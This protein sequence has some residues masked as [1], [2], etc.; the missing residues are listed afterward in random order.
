MNVPVSVMMLQDRTGYEVLQ[1]KHVDQTMAG[2]AFEEG[3]C[4][5]DEGGDDFRHVNPTPGIVALYQYQDF[6]FAVSSMTKLMNGTL[7]VIAAKAYFL[8]RFDWRVDELLK[9]DALLPARAATKIAKVFKNDGHGFSLMKLARLFFLDGWEIG[10]KRIMRFLTMAKHP[11][12]IFGPKRLF[13]RLQE[14]WARSRRRFWVMSSGQ[15]NA[16]SSTGRVRWVGVS[17][18][19]FKASEVA[20][21]RALAVSKPGDTVMAVHYPKD[22]NSLFSMDLFP[23][24]ATEIQAEMINTRKQLLSKVQDIV[25]ESGHEARGVLFRAFVGPASTYRPAYALCEDAKIAEVKP[26]RIYVGYD[27]DEHHRTFT[28]YVV[29]H[30]PCDVAIIKGDFRGAKGSEEGEGIT[31][32]VGISERNFDVSGAALAKAFAHSQFGDT[33]VAVHYP[34]NPFEGEGLS[35]VFCEH[36]SSM[37]E[38]Q[39]DVI[40]DDVEKRVLDNTTRIAEIYHKKGVEFKFMTGDRTNEPHLRLVMDATTNF[41]RPGSIY[42]GYN[43]RR[44]RNRL[45]DPHKL[46]DVAEFVVRNAPCNVV[47]VKETQDEMA[48]RIKKRRA[49][50]VVS[51]DRPLGTPSPEVVPAPAAA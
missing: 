47:V 41:K 21:R 3:K 42:V 11:S 45:V 29:R 18:D 50:E 37:A 19:K 20:L 38:Q 25:D 28:D 1:Q 27:S 9:G 40:V 13:Q 36:F 32:W 2:V 17:L 46:Y 8:Q 4:E 34:A 51:D 16:S 26:Y 35:S 24:M 43:R 48:E 7:P 30:A 49:A 39:L 44:D 22:M 10:F 15:I 23:D 33:V 31:R 14:S 5:V 6:T 12:D